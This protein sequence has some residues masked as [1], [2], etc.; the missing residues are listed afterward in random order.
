MTTQKANV[1]AD[2]EVQVNNL[3]KFYVH[4]YE[5]RMVEEELQKNTS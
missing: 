3:T 1:L 4:T 2:L 5:K